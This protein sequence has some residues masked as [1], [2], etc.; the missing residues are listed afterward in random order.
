MRSWQGYPT[1]PA[2]PVGA[3]RDADP[4]PATKS[5]ELT[6]RCEKAMLGGAEVGAKGGDFVFELAKRRPVRLKVAMKSLTCRWR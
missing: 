1:L 3:G 4:N 5:V 2:Q 6:N